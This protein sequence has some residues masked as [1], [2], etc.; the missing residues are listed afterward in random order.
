M[1]T[2]LHRGEC[3]CVLSVC[4]V[5]Y[6]LNL[7]KNASA[8]RTVAAPVGRSVVWFLRWSEVFGC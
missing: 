3:A 8:L 7:K 1:R 5:L 2:C 6:N 4:V